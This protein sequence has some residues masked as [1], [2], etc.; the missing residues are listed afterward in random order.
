MHLPGKPVP[1]FK[2]GLRA[3]THASHTILI[4]GVDE[5]DNEKAA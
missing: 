3:C 1:F 2:N 5:N 4:D